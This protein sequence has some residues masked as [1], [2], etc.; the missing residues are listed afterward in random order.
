[1]E[2]A[3]EASI[4]VDSGY[5]KHAF[6][7]VAGCRSLK[8]LSVVVSDTIFDEIQ[9]KL[10]WTSKFSDTELAKVVHA[11][12]MR[13]TAELRELRFIPTSHSLYIQTENELDIFTSN[14]KRLE[15]LTW[16]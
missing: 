14:L 4:N 6:G 7:V 2:Y 11:N 3:T 13:V 16:D 1:M 5:V 8:V 15:Q 10:A 9:D 12:G